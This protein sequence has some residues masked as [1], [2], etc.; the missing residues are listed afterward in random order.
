MSWMA[1]RTTTRAEDIAYCLL[2]LFEVTISMS[3]E[4][5]EHA[6]VRLQL[7][8]IKMIDDHS[9][10]AW[11][12][13]SDQDT[14]DEDPLVVPGGAF[15]TSPADF[16]N[17][18]KVF[19]CI[20]HKQRSSLEFIGG[21]LRMLVPLV[22]NSAG[23]LFGLLNCILESDKERVV[24]IPLDVVLADESIGN[25]FRPPGR[26]SR[27]FPR[28]QVQ[29]SNF[30]SICIRKDTPPLESKSKS[31]TNCF[32]IDES[33]A[34]VKLIDVAPKDRWMEHRAMILISTS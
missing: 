17:S 32:F 18:G 25:Y 12:F 31:R 1:N 23:Q 5:R 2:G 20:S 19:P 21:S 16:V 33:A 24:G 10:L 26:K 3:Y 6:F 22:K 7:E 8:I 27:L 15:A 11:G 13:T 34:M 28:D 29:D 30:K 14:L 4:E 9:I